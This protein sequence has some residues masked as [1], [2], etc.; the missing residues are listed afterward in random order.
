MQIYVSILKCLT[1]GNQFFLF[2]LAIVLIEVDSY[3]CAYKYMHPG[4]TRIQTDTQTDIRIPKNVLGK[5]SKILREIKR[6]L[7]RNS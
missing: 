1:W 4:N 5:I 6:L 2:A 7:C 3:V